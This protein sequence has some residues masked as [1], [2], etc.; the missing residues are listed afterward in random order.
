[1][2]VKVGI[3]DIAREVIVETESSAAELEQQLEAALR[4]DLVFTLTETKGRKVLIP[5]RTIAYVDL[6]Q[7]HVRTVGFGAV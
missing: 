6:G 3:R 7:E 5:A 1:M 2:E 4:D